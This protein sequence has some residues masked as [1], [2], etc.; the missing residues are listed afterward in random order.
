MHA[1][2]L[3]CRAVVG[4]SFVC[5]TFDASS[6]GQPHVVRDLWAISDVLLFD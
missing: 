6:F 4:G 2:V 1:R 5:F 3:G